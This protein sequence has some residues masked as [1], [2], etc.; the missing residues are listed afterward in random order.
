M[1]EIGRVSKNFGSVRAVRDVSLTIQPGRVTGLLGPNGAGKTTLI[2]MI[3]GFITPSSGSVK[4][5][6][7]DSIVNSAAARAVT[8]YLPESAPCY[9]EMRVTDFLRFRAELFGV[10]RAERKAAVESAIQRCWLTEMRWRAIGNLSKGYRQ[11]VGLAAAILHDPRVVILDEPTTGL[12]PSQ[13]RE[14]RTL[15]RDLAKD[16]ASG[17]QRVVLLSSHILAE[18]EATCDHVIIMARGQVRAEGSPA[19]L[20]AALRQTAPYH[21]EVIAPSAQHEA[22]AR[23]LSMIAGITKVDIGHREESLLT[24]RV[25]ADAGAP[26]L[27]ESI[28]R[29]LA[30]QSAIV[31]ELTRPAATL[32]QVF[33]NVVE[34]AAA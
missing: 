24:L 21:V 9:P 2:R 25:Q 16:E 20:T 29:L 8:G 26:D 6:G 31:R 34:H 17:A 15:I 10:S 7:H 22:I 30:S 4:I 32:E 28:A 3:T 14:M 23:T 19:T 18:V 5:V 27:R 13:I 1:I 12:D 33:V 11:R